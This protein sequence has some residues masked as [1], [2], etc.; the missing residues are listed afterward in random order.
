M[1]RSRPYLDAIQTQPRRRERR[2][3]AAR[4]PHRRPARTQPPPARECPYSILEPMLKTCL[5]V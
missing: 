2:R 1:R 5:T 4:T 3:R